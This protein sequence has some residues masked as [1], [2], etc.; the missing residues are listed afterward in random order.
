MTGKKLML[1]LNL[2]RKAK[3]DAKVQ[4]NDDG[5]K[6]GDI[7]LTEMN[8]ML[9]EALKSPTSSCQ[10][11]VKNLDEITGQNDIVTRNSETQRK[12]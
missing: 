8:K 4:Q 7:E 3:N 11:C 12:Y 6:R 5:T 2:K 1:I 9:D 10:Q